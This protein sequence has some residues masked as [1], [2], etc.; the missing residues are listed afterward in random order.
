M[1]LLSP[2]N[3]LQTTEEHLRV[4]GSE[5]PQF[6]PLKFHIPEAG[7]IDLS[8]IHPI[9]VLRKVCVEQT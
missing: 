6:P 4:T 5:P 3:N 8:M 2:Q 7:L 1:F 9:K